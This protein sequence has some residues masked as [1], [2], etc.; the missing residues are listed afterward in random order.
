LNGCGECELCIGKESVP[1]HCN[2]PDSG[3]GQCPVGVQA[4]GR[5]NQDPCPAGTYCITGCCIF[6][7]T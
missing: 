5:K 6:V 2:D 7:P 1:E 4:C 3:T